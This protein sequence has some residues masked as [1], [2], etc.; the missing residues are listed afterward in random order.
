MS[1]MKALLV[2]AYE[3]LDR[4]ATEKRI[5]NRIVSIAKPSQVGSLYALSHWDGKT[6]A[7]VYLGNFRIYKG[8]TREFPTFL[9]IAPNGS[10]ILYCSESKKILWYADGEDGPDWP[11]GLEVSR[12]RVT[13]GKERKKI[14]EIVGVGNSIAELKKALERVAA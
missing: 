10:Y 3:N 4:D 1:D 11:A 8:N 2:L 13:R 5:G 14:E 6:T 9:R 12:L 7:G